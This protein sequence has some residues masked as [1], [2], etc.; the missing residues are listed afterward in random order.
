[1]M[2]TSSSWKSYLY[3]LT[4]EARLKY[5]EFALKDVILDGEHDGG[6]WCEDVFEAPNS[7]GSHFIMLLMQQP[8]LPL[9]RLN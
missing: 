8:P 1:M 2:Q 5:Y 4:F 3:C 9:V 6:G 7:I